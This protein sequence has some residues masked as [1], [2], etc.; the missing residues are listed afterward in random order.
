MLSFAYKWLGEEKIHCRALCDYPNYKRNKHDDGELVQELH[1]LLSKADFIVAHNGDAFDIKRTNARLMLHGLDPPKPSKTIDT[2][3]EARKTIKG[4]SNRLDALA[5]YFGYGRKLPH[6]GK[7]LWLGCVRGDM[8]AWKIMKRYNIH[9]VYLLEKV[10]LKLRPWMK[11]H[12]NLSI[13]TRKLKAC[14]KCQSTHTW[15]Q[16]FRYT[17]TGESQQYQCLDCF[18]WFQGN[19]VKLDNKIEF[20]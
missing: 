1:G 17:R 16:G 2:L 4:N 12:P 10:Y 15:K 19:Y 20:R 5:R 6:T 14:P 3:K 8:K 9:D 11:N 18:S 7:D 13:I